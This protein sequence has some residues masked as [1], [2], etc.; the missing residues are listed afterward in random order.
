MTRKVTASLSLLFIVGLVLFDQGTARL[1]P[2]QAPAA[3]ALGSGQ[4]ASGGFCG[5]LPQ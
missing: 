4:V 5:A 3:F 1:N 2:Y